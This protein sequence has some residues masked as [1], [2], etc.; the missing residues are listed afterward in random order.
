MKFQLAKIIIFPTAPET[1]ILTQFPSDSHLGDK[2]KPRGKFKCDTKHTKRAE[3]KGK[4][5]PFENL[6]NYSNLISLKFDREFVECFST[7]NG[8]KIHHLQYEHLNNKIC[9]FGVLK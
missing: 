8:K 2:S 6:S 3:I 4:T 7:K 5:F 9:N 1:N